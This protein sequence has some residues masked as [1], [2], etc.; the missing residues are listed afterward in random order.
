MEEKD[1][2][3]IAFRTHEGHY[4]FLVMPFGL[5]N[6]PATFQALMN[7]IFVPYLR[8][9][10]LVFF[11]DILIYSKDEEEHKSH[12]GIV[13]ATLIEHS[14]YANKKKCCF[15]QS[16]VEYLGHVISGKGVVDPEK[17]RA[18]AD[19]TIPKTVREVRGFL[20][21]TGY[22]RCF[23]QHY[24]CIAASLTQLLKKGGF[25]WNKEAE[26]AFGRLNWTV[27]RLE[28]ERELMTV[29]LAV[30]RWPPYLLEKWLVAL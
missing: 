21:L 17:I 5:T 18:I 30:Q 12:F 8:K 1:I 24:G 13:L 9:F 6:A 22:Y 4:E 11:D 15:A 10:V 26:E 2:P 7:N 20:G 23:V 25:M 29:V 14:L 27:Q 28:D 3:K 16:R 19:W